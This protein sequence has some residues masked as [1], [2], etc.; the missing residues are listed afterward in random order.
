MGY[1]PTETAPRTAPKTLPR[2]LHPGTHPSLARARRDVLVITRMGTTLGAAHLRPGIRYR[3]LVAEGAQ[4]AGP[5]ARLTDLARAGAHVRTVPDVPLDAMVVDGS[6]AVLPERRRG[7]AADAATVLIRV[8]ESL[9]S[10][11]TPF[12]APGLTTRERE[13]LVMLSE[14]RTDESMAAQLGLSVRTVRRMISALMVRLD[15]RSRFQ[16]GVRAA[17][18]GWPTEVS[19]RPSA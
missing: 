18:L 8:F 10:A 15:A 2:T 7:M 17:N 6:L 4:L 14:G 11:G 1:W 19:R 3:I 5:A 9:W 12:D 13:V 16:A